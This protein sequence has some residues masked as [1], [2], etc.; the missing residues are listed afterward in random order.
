MQGDDDSDYPAQ[1][2]VQ[3]HVHSFGHESST[4]RIENVEIWR[5]GQAYRLGRFPLHFNRVGFMRNSYVRYNSIHHSYNRAKLPQ[6]EE[7]S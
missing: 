1:Y 3:I 7:R 6:D 2:G 4:V 5:C